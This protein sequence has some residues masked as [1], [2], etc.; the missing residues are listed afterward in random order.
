MNAIPIHKYSEVVVF[1]E[2]L[3][4]VSLGFPLSA[5]LKMWSSYVLTVFQTMHQ[6][7]QELA[8]KT[9]MASK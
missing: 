7:N 3:S 6:G 2:S 9:P 8:A 1:L 5:L 4:K